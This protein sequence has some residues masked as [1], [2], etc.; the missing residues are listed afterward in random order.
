VRGKSS[1]SLHEQNYQGEE[2]G[3]AK[4][5]TRREVVMMK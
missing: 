1:G 4:P 5:I 3:C 2:K